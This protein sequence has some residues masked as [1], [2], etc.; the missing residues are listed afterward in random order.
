MSLLGLDLGT[1]GCK[2]TIFNYTGRIIESAYREY[3]L[4]TPRPGWV[5]LDPTLVWRKV[6][7]LLKE[8]A[9]KH[10]G[11]PI[12]ALSISSMGEAAVP[13]DKK[14]RV[15]GP[16]L[17]YT[18]R[19]GEE[20]VNHLKESFGEEHIM[21]I[22]GTKSHSMYTL[23]KILYLRKNSPHIYLNTWKFLLY[24]DFI[25]FRLGGDPLI[26]YSLASRTM[27]FHIH[28]REWSEEILSSVGCEKDL[29]S[30]AVP[31]GTIAGTLNKELARE[32]GLPPLLLVVGGHDQPLGAL[33]AGIIEESMAVD[34]MGT[35]ECITTCLKEPLSLESLER[36]HLVTVPHVIEDLY[37]TY[38]FTFTGGSLLKWFRDTFGEEEIQRA[39]RE[40]EDV[41]TL[42]LQEVAK[43]PTN[44]FILPHFSG[45]GT[46]YMDAKASG[47]ILGLT[48]NTTRG[49][50][51]R[52]ILEGV[53]Y[54]MMVNL[55]ILE[56]AGIEL[57]TLRVMGGGARS[58]FNLQLKADMMGKRLKTL[59]V[60]EAGTLGG[61][62]L[63]GRACGIFRSLKE[64]VKEMV[65]V[66]REYEVCEDV[67]RAYQERFKVYKEIYP[68]I[69]G[70]YVKS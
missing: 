48:L 7:D 25:L 5:E 54:E 28:K 47:A 29:F 3:P 53:T 62:I 8:V 23:S 63:A 51:I 32:L 33:G 56:E 19:R 24:A 16:S 30:K 13:I 69:K 52:G 26:D 4:M 17:L 11:E 27:A 37:V 18:D 49:E 39:R 43:E 55:E 40:G 38:A 68:A 44:L 57:S 50:M 12:K 64:A 20:E 70:M 35:V 45:T 15:L 1:T 10:R 46:P 14:G 9:S 6:K 61:A 66:E 67:H 65:H 58:P 34:G 22:T 60:S 36:F 42:L 2:A 21:K 59:S 31:S 41:Y